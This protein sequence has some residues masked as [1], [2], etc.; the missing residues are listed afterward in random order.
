MKPK[1]DWNS[2]LGAHFEHYFH[3]HKSSFFHKT[4]RKSEIENQVRDFRLFGAS[5]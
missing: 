3:M 1:C 2:L 5:D 4:Y